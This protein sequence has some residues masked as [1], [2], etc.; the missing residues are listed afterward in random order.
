MILEKH[1]I[2]ESDVRLANLGSDLNR[3]EALVAGI[4][5][6]GVVASEFV[7]VA[8]S[9]LKVLATARDILP[10]YVR[11]CLMMRGET[12]TARRAAAIQFVTAE[13]EA[14]EFA[15]TQRDETITL[16]RK[17]IQAK[18][19]DP[20]AAFVYEDAISHGAVDPLIKL[21][22]EKLQWM[23]DQLLKAGTLKR[24]FDLNKIIDTQ[25]RTTAVKR[26]G[27]QER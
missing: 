3:F 13:M 27:K 9:N 15:L 7:S 11:L 6:A 10:N 19:S 1:N 12:L 8:P 23:H 22:F 14:L 18:P 2:A 16:T 24:P 25:V 20:R 21:P 5:D 4:A 26:L 17:L